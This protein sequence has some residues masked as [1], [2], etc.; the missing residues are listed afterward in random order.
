MIKRSPLRKTLTT[1]LTLFSVTIFISAQ[2]ADNFS[3]EDN[4]KEDLK[5]NVCEDK[6]RLAAV[7]LLFK[8]FGATDDE[9]IIDKFKNVENLVVTKKGKTGETVIVGAHYDKT[10]EG[11]GAIDNW[12]G[13]VI[14]ANLYKT[15]RNFSTEKTYLFVAFGK[16]ELGLVGSEAMARAIPKE[17]RAGYCS[18]VNFDSFGFTYP[19]VLDN[20]SNSKMTKMAKETAKQMKISLASASLAGSADADSTS[21]INKDIPAVTFHGLSDKWKDYLHGSKDKLE[22]VNAQ[23]VY[24]GYRYGFNFLAN[25]DKSDCGIFR[26]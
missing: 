3:T 25:I 4:I 5:L 19:Q 20:V 1:L 14:I 11:C 2:S 24:I 17:K 13:I 21:F 7:K 15:L 18:M 22:Y 26:R 6:E 23:S 9:I 10:S 16:E 12:T 8:K